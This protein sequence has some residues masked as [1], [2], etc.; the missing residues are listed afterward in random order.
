MIRWQRL[1]LPLGW[2]YGGVMALRNLC[3][4]WGLLPSKRFDVPVIAVGN[5]SVG[6][7]GKTPM[8]EALIDQLS[9]KYR[10]GVVSRGYG[11]YTRGL[12]VAQPDSTATQLGDEP[13]QI[14]RKFPQIKLVVS[15][16][17]VLGIQHLLQQA[18]PPDLILLDDAYQHRWVK[19]YKY[20][21]LTSCNALYPDDAVLP[22]G[23][24]RE[25]RSGKKR[26]QAVVVTKCPPDLNEEAQQAIRQRLR[27]KVPVFFTSI[28]QADAWVCNGKPLAN[29]EVQAQPNM[30]VAG[31]AHPQSFFDQVAQPH[32]LCLTFPDHH[33]F[34]DTELQQL[35]QHL[36]SGY[37][38]LLTTEKDQ[39][40]L[41]GHIPAQRLAY[42]PI[43]TQWLQGDAQWQ[44]LLATWLKD[45]NK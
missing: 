9:D 10:I 21:L 4:D 29:A 41:Q 7:T 5:L 11:R 43:Q 27:V 17:R 26:A 22:A 24:L 32:D 34:S 13:Y 36:E 23:R 20:I 35:Q 39:V 15:E 44:Q 6:G 16:K 14:Y 42:K 1:L 3:F 12:V 19:A 25:F 40:R 33:H 45:F 8:V 18:Q 28:G 31:I 38:Y 30:V 2:V 37:G